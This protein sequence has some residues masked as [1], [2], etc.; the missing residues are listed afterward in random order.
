MQRTSEPLTYYMKRFTPLL[1]IVCL[2]TAMLA[3]SAHAA[4]SDQP[5]KIGAIFSVTGP[6]SFLG[7][8]EEKTARMLIDK[9]NA[10]GGV[11]GRKL[12]LTIKDSSGSPEKAVSFARQ[13][14]EEDKVLAIVGPST[15]G[16]TMQ[17]KALCEENKMI[18]VSCAAAEVIVN[19][20]A[21]YV[22]KTP[23]KDSQ[24]VMWIYRTAKEQGITKI[25][26][27]SGN[28]GFGVAGKKQLEDLAKPEGIEILV[29][30]VYDK[31][32]TDLMDIMT[33][34]KANSGVQAVVNWSIVPAQSI[35]AK[36]MKQIGLNV[37][38][39]QSHG[40]GNRKYVEQGGPATEGTL[41]PAGRLLVVEELPDD[42]PQKKLLAE[43]KAD[44]ERL[45]KED[46]STFGGHAYDAVL[47]VVEGLRKAGSPDREK[48]RDAIENLKGLVGTAGVFNFSPTDH[49]GLDLNA[50]EMLTVKNGKFAIYK[51]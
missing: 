34:V 3:G 26:V 5:V 17:I 2:G 35:V 8:P 30:E 33:K 45:Y 20:V 41:F 13:L 32:A 11:N 16:E 24:A 9:I 14:I 51:K 39:F 38:L 23:Q 47:V 18:L 42:H 4:S 36:N 7:A 12:Q 22:F 28:D 27:L 37:P 49:T 50:F 46:V 15:S 31:Q 10:S 1:P 40:F 44:Y 43:Y 25:A 19:P 6:A 21:R 48:V 29:N